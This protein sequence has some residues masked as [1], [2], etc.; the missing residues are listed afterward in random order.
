MHREISQHSVTR[1]EQWE[2]QPEGHATSSRLD[3]KKREMIERL[4]KSMR[5]KQCL[6]SFPQVLII[7]S[8][9]NTNRYKQPLLEI[10][11]FTS[12][13]K[14]FIVA[15]DFLSSENKETYV[16]ALE[17]L[18][19]VMKCM[20]NVIVTDRDLALVL[21]VENV[22]STSAHLLCRRHI[23]MDI[24]SYVTKMMKNNVMGKSV[25]KNWKILIKGHSRRIFT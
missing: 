4:S 2:T 16:W 18:K 12:T 1:C 3:K 17:C 21:D 19:N 10:V 14:T 20:P 15:Y 9:Y 13:W 24:E 6:H 22:F 11:G 5:P 8:T 23:D 7:Y 25:A